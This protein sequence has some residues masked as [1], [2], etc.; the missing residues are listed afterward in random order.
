MTLR[1]L[2]NARPYPGRGCLLAVTGPQ[3]Y[4]VYFVTGRS[5]ASR[6]RSL[7]VAQSGAVDVTDTR[8]EGEHDSLRHYRAVSTSGEWQVVGNGDHVESVT[9]ALAAGQDPHSIM[10]ALTVEPDPPIY[11][12]RIW[13]GA[14]RGRSDLAPIFGYARRRLDGGVD[15][16]IWS[17]SDL[18]SGWGVLLSTYEGT[19]E[20]VRTAF[21]PSEVALAAVDGPSL[22]SEVWEA[23]D[24]TIRV[25]AVLVTPDS[26]IPPSVV[27]P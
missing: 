7:A 19:A 9:R 14:R 10:T 6:S 24:P 5:P 8:L 23:L 20:A 13:L 2:L 4:M 15:R 17:V 18:T 25:G 1:G 27:L 16:V 21:C 12:P 11:T 26:Q 3:R 22:L